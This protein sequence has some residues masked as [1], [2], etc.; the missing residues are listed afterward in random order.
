[1]RTFLEKGAD[2]NTANGRGWAALDIALESQ[3]REVANLLYA[4]GAHAPGL[5]R[6][7]GRILNAR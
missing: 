7:Q 3:F 2:P 6:T 4:A 5:A 1:V